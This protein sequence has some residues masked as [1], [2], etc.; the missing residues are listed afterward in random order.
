MTESIHP[1]PEHRIFKFLD[2][3]EETDH[4][5]FGG[6]DREIAEV[7][8]RVTTS[9]TH[10]LFGQ[11]GLGKTSL[12]LAGVFPKLRSRGWLPIYVRTLE[13]PVGDLTRALEEE[14]HRQSPDVQ[15]ADTTAD[16]PDE[17]PR[18][19]LESIAKG[20]NPPIIVVLDQFEEFFIR[21]PARS[22]RRK[23]FIRVIADIVKTSTLNVHVMFSLREDYL[24]GLYDFKAHIPELTTN[25]LRLLPMSAFGVRQAILRPLLHA[26][27]DYDNRLIVNLVDLLDTFGF[28]SVMLQIICYEVHNE[29]LSRNG[30]NTKLTDSDLKNVGGIDGIFRRYLDNVT[31]AIPETE[32]LLARMVLNALITQERT[33][34][35]MK[36]SDFAK[37]SFV[38]DEKDVERILDTLVTQRLVRRE[39]RG[40][41]PWYELIHERLAPIIDEWLRRDVMFI[42]FMAARELIENGAR[43]EQWRNRAPLLLNEG[44][45]QL[46]SPYQRLLNLSETQV[47]FVLCSIIYRRMAGVR[48]W[49]ERFGKAKSC[50]LIRQ[51][52]AHDEKGMREG[53]AKAVYDCPPEDDDKVGAICT[54][55]ALEDPSQEVRLAAGKALTRVGAG[56]EIGPLK[57]ALKRS[58]TRKVALQALSA[59]AGEDHP[60]KEINWF[61]RARARRMY[62]KR[63]FKEHRNL[64]SDCGTAGAL[65]GLLGGMGWTATVFAF[66]AAII[67]YVGVACSSWWETFAESL[68]VGLPISLA[69]GAMIGR[70][71]S[72]SLGRLAA[73]KQKLDWVQTIR[74]SWAYRVVLIV[75]ICLPLVVGIV[76]LIA[77]ITAP[78][79]NFL[80][81]ILVV[82]LIGTV[83]LLA[84]WLWPLSLKSAQRVLAG[85]ITSPKR[86]FLWS[87]LGSMAIPVVVPLALVTPFYWL[88]VYCDI[89][90]EVFFISA[91]ILL[92]VATIWSFFHAVISV[93]LVK[94]TMM[95]R[96]EHS[97]IVINKGTTTFHRRLTLFLTGLAMMSPTIF[98]GVDALPIARSEGEI[99]PGAQTFPIGGEFDNAVFD[100]NR[101]AFTV[102]GDAHEIYMLT[103]KSQRQ[104]FAVDRYKGDAYEAFHMLVQGSHRYVITFTKRSSGEQLYQSNLEVSPISHLPETISDGLL[105]FEGDIGAYWLVLHSE[106]DRWI[107][108]HETS[109]IRAQSLHILAPQNALYT[110]NGDCEEELPVTMFLNQVECEFR[111]YQ[112]VDTV[113]SLHSYDSLEKKVENDYFKQDAFKCPITTSTSQIEIVLKPAFDKHRRLGRIALPEDL[114]VLVAIE[115]TT[116]QREMAYE[117]AAQLLNSGNLDA[118][119]KIMTDVLAS[120]PQFLN[121]RGQSRMGRIL[122]ELDEN[123]RALDAWGK[124]IEID[125]ENADALAGEA[126]AMASQ[127]KWDRALASYRRA[128][129]RSEMYLDPG[130]LKAEQKWTD[131]AVAQAEP[132]IET[133]Q[134]EYRPSGTTAP[135]DLL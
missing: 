34:Q 110:Q 122:F 28:D 17:T 70:L 37:G 120:S 35:A 117:E 108:R 130:W 64:I 29:A 101:H 84:W 57:R 44:Q 124:A 13:D 49:T 47:E 106:G 23:E 62:R 105:K 61:N 4:A 94:S 83:P 133:I 9:R 68:A 7:V 87:L 73:L 119:E 50:D 12:L 43:S 113:L 103:V 39:M 85:R 98:F 58:E 95:W 45:L 80:S 97:A 38:A 67:C 109:W 18:T 19:L 114:K 32:H 21:F 63:V 55:L 51:L 96:N 56:R 54:K 81:I 82:V 25:E 78:P 121:G 40:E 135:D 15:A 42:D 111:S 104:P 107:A 77:V 65:S 41:D 126:I 128:V 8:N 115:K 74:K 36:L 60:L 88:H 123:D 20:S 52:L 22:E 59:M 26:G 118:A 93:A 1:A 71:V 125:P 27:I 16:T 129:D 131:K 31:T 89:D 69:V 72:R 127:K 46:V 24:A 90:D 86:V 91:V 79:E 6:R 112:T 102:G 3:Y 10:V 134:A 132:L 76:A 5:A 100:V 2:Y 30:Q 75:F 53:A 33:K 92:S 116:V 11:S 66:F 14:R 48:F 99:S